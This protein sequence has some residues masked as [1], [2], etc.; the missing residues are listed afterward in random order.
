MRWRSRW[1]TR[2]RD[3][4]GG[5]R[6]STGADCV[7]VLEADDSRVD[8]VAASLP[9][10]APGARRR[11][12]A[13]VAGLGDRAWGGRVG[14]DGAGGQ[15]RV[16]RGRVWA[17]REFPMR[18]V[19]K[20]SIYRHEV[21]HAA[22]EALLEA[23]G[24]IASARCA[25]TGSDTRAVAGGAARPLMTQDVRAID[26]ELGRHR[27]GASQDSRRGGAPR[28]ARRRSRASSF[29]SS[30]GIASACCAAGRGRSSPRATGAICRATRDGAV[31]ITHLKRR[32]TPTER[33]FKLP[34]TRALSLAGIEPRRA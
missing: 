20:S 31:W 25:P 30:A 26:W 16:R 28:G 27:G 33:L 15:R 18:D 6:A 2:G 4:G 23:I 34:A 9:G 24:Q 12:G 8:L 22:I 1:S 3:G 5:R 13:F 14:G 11:P 10:R 7:P 19:G 17:T 29:I 21:R 32:D